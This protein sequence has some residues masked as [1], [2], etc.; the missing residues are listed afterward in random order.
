MEFLM[1]LLIFPVLSFIFGIIGQILIKR[2]Y[3]VVGITLL[4]W[5]IATF[6]IFNDSFLI[7]VFIYSILSMIGALIVCYV[8]KPKN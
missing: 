7:W 6:T 5:L 3:I 8:K 4:C 1:A 2:V